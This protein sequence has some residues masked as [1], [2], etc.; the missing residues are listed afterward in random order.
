[1]NQMPAIIAFVLAGV[2]LPLAIQCRRLWPRLSALVFAVWLALP[3][4]TAYL[5]NAW[6]SS[7]VVVSET[8]VQDRPREIP[9]DG[10]VQ[11]VNC[12]ACHPDQYS[13]WHDSYH[14]TMT[15]LANP[16]SVLGDFNDT[17]LQIGGRNYHLS[18]DGEKYFVDVSDQVSS[19]GTGNAPRSHRGEI[20][21]TTGSHHMQAYWYTSGQGRLTVQLPFVWLVPEQAWLAESH[22]FLK[23]DERHGNDKMSNWNTTC[24]NCHTTHGC[25]GGVQV[26]DKIDTQAAEFGIACESCHGPAEEHVAVNRSP[27]QRYQNHFSDGQDPTIKNPANMDHRQASEVCGSCHAGARLFA[28]ADIA[29]EAKT[30][31]RIYR[32]GGELADERLILQP[33]DGKTLQN[34]L[35]RSVLRSQPQ[36]LQ[37]RFWSDGLARVS[38]T[39]YNAMV[40]SPCYTEG[41]MSCLSCHAMHSSGGDSRPT[42]EWTDDQLKVGMRGNEACT[43]CHAELDSEEALSA[44]SRHDAGSSGS[45]CYNCH[46]PYTT[47][48]LL[49]AIR[50]HTVTSPNA[51]ESLMIGRPN[52]CNQCHMDKPLS[53]TADQLD[54][55][56]GIESPSIPSE[57]K[58]VAATVQ[59]TLTGDAGQRA[60][61]AWNLGWST[62]HD[63]AGNDWQAP[64]LAHLLVDP[65]PAVRVVANRSLRRLPNFADF[66]YDLMGSATDR[67]KARQGALAIWQANQSSRQGTA[68][69]HVLI[70]ADGSLDKTRFDRL[71]AKRNNRFISLEE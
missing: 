63:V 45:L 47:F 6:E 68:K 65:Y 53:W 14:R 56:F 27:L 17:D 52:A 60:L 57:Q 30:N 3:I 34:P 9:R 41:E 25:Q 39:E 32:P 49:K 26:T 43:Q 38:G 19:D 31:G 16:V 35:V 48:G 37:G 54:E 61:M 33:R 70:N 29:R 1:M 66:Q 62:A 46:M 12:R 50:S 28:S 71:S 44:H 2:L 8:A 59:W 42:H 4:G 40:D 55:W 20:V 51:L 23:P 18:R 64:F 67:E 15:Q 10:Y 24:I 5:A 58:D 22:S 21:M 7:R 11:S 69:P 36:L 13:S